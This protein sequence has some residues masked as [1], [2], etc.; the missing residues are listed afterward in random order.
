[1]H[2]RFFPLESFPIEGT[3]IRWWFSGRSFL[4]PCAQSRF[5]PHLLPPPLLTFLSLVICHSSTFKRWHES[6]WSRNFGPFFFFNCNLTPAITR[7]KIATVFH[8]SVNATFS[9]AMVLRRSCI[10]PRF[11][12]ALWI[13]SVIF[14]RAAL[15]SICFCA[16][17]FSCWPASAC[18]WA[19]RSRASDNLLT[20]VWII[21]CRY[22]ITACNWEGI[23]PN[24]NALLLFRDADR[25]FSENTR[26]RVYERD[27]TPRAFQWGI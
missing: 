10:S 7:E 25:L 27:V 13:V 21:A 16:S 22:I 23:R 12:P 8:L 14:C 4:L 5:F 19:T 1:M 26:K 2:V 17:N 20:P 15:A 6:N 11:T 9:V 24:L 18:K 3:P